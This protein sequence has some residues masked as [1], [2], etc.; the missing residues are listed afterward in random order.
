[1][2]FVLDNN[3]LFSLMNPSSIASY[4][5]YSVKAEFIAP[6]FIKYEFEKYKDIILSKSKLSGQEF[7]I[8]KRE[9]E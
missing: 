8:R 6:K 3:I 2:M 5:F 7:E 9:I 4:L 1:M